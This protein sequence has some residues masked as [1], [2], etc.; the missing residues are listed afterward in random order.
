MGFLVAQTVQ[1]PSAMQETQVW[2][3]GQEDPL[4][5]GMAI[6]SSILALRI[7]WTE[8]TARLQYMGLQR[9]RHDWATNTLNKVCMLFYNY[10]ST[11][12]QLS[13]SGYTSSTKGIL[14]LKEL[15][16]KT[17]PWKYRTQNCEVWPQSFVL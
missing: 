10:Y 3:L 8:V 7:L 4:E 15:I 13:R 12:L 1:D 2:S 9:I 16:L 6:H 5:E 17:F 11:F 14:Y